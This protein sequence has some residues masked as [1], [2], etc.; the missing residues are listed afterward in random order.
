MSESGTAMRF[1]CAYLSV[2]TQRPVRLFGTGRQHERP[3]AP[4]VEALRS[5]GAKITD[6]DHE[7]YPPLLIEPS[8]FSWQGCELDASASSQYLSALLLLAPLLPVGF[9]VDTRGYGLA[10]R[11][12]ALMTKALL[13]EQGFVWEEEP[14]GLFCY[15]GKRVEDSQGT[16]ILDRGYEADWSGASYAFAWLSLLPLGSTM[17][18]PGLCYPS[19]QGDAGYL[20]SFFKEL[21]VKTLP[22]GRGVKLQRIEHADTIAPFTASMHECPDLVPALV[23]TLVGQGR[24]FTL[25]GVAHLRIKESDR[26]EALRV[27]LAK[28]GIGL[29]LGED[30]ISWDAH[31]WISPMES[32]PILAT[33]GDHRIAMAL[34]VLTIPAG[35][36]LL[37]HPEVVSKSFPRYWEGLT[38]FLMVEEN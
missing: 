13:Q 20:V 36:V 19:L 26:L 33:H 29:S 12:Y 30:S 22:D 11:P 4:L 25:T 5:Q 21:G 32:P 17:E 2:T 3:I 23:T 34:S 6:L 10:S 31:A 9:G 18:L 24:P 7:G 1:V 28:L 16:S 14:S 35:T 15:R 27:E 38:P 8:T 37:E